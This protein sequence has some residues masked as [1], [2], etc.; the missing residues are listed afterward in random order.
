MINYERKKAIAEMNAMT[1]E[2]FCSLPD[3]KRQKLIEDAVSKDK[4]I[5]I[6][7]P[8]KS[9]TISKASC[10]FPPTHVTEP[11][12]STELKDRSFWINYIE[13]L[14]GE[15]LEDPHGRVRAHPQKGSVTEGQV[16]G[17]TEQDVEADGE[18]AEDGETLHQVRVAGVEGREAG[19]LGEGLQGD[20]RDIGAVVSFTGLVREMT[21][22]GAIQTMELEHYPGMTESALEEI[23][24]Q[25]QARWPLQGVR[26]IHRYGPMEPGEGIVLVLTASRHRQALCKGLTSQE[27]SG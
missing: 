18:D 17:Q 21:E 19:A 7:I 6:S 3:E 20:R 1:E 15:E 24:A 4:V 23:V 25:A 12:A 26:L 10:S 5:V 8:L 16:P 27:G 14:G 2:E 13:I 11:Q 22:A 9:N